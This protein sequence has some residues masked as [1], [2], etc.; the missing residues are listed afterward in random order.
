MKTTV[1]ISWNNP[2]GQPNHVIMDNWGEM[3]SFL[4]INKKV[5]LNVEVFEQSCMTCPI[6]DLCDA[7]EDME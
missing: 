2:D 5:D 7:R 1:R 6:Q 4:C 3:I